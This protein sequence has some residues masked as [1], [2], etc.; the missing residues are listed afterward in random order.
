MP[1]LLIYS[2]HFS[3]KTSRLSNASVSS[4]EAYASAEMQTAEEKLM[5]CSVFWLLALGW[6][7]LGPRDLAESCRL[8][9]WAFGLGLYGC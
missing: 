6:S 7:R 2:L 3:I 8:W 4:Y 9:L 1:L 5:P